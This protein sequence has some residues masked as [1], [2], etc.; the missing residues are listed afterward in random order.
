[1][2]YVAQGSWFEQSFTKG[3][4]TMALDLRNEKGVPL[5]KQLF[6]WRDLVRTPIS[7]LN[8][9]AFTRVRIILMNGIE[10]ESLNFQHACA[11]MNHRLRAALAEVRML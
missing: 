4:Q 3:G 1:L 8:D 2:P 7:K 5:D 11:R 6:T 9:D 10:M